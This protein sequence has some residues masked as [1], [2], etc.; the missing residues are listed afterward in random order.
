[1]AIRQPTWERV[2]HFDFSGEMGETRLIVE[3]M[4]KRSNLALTVEG[5]IMDC[6]K[7]VGPDQNRYRVLL[8]GKPYV[9]PPP[10][11]KAHPEQVTVSMMDGFLKR[12][13][14]QPTWQAL[15]A[16]I[17][18]I[19]PLFAR[20][21]VYFASGDPEA[22]AFDVA[23]GMIH[24]AFAQRV[25]EVSAGQWQPCVVPSPQGDGYVAFAAYS[26]THLDGWQPVD[27]ISRAM[28]L[29]FGA[30]VGM[31]AYRAGKEPVR[32]QIAEAQKRV[33]RKLAA[34]ERQLVGEEK[35]ETLRKQGE[36]ILA[37][38]AT[39]TPG[40]TALTAQYDPDGPV[41][42]IDL[43]PR[44]SYADNAKEYFEKYDKAKRA[45][46]D[47]PKLLAR[48]RHE[49]AY[50]QQLA[51]DLD[52]AENWT[53]IDT[54]REE[55]QVAGLWR[56]PHTHGPKGSKLGIRR[57]TT[58]DGFVILIGRNAAQNHE[59]VTEKA[60]GSDLWLHARRIP[61]SHVIVKQGG[62]D[63]SDDV[64][65]RA[66]EIAA[67]YSAARGDTSVEVDVTERRYVRPIKGGRPG[68]VTYKNERT[69]RVKPKK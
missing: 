53:E 25:G 47:V 5:E 52:L 14:S 56:G 29:Y 54:V 60:S 7:R 43:D 31:D 13:T 10:Q 35:I 65:Q 57:L 22:P 8:P 39:L 51:T 9:P 1:M 30:P 62:R 18:G 15:V 36:L 23:A 48:T 69:L 21:I 28:A 34:L 68:M 66:A 58:G 11:D 3:T 41:Y 44:L 37:Y 6:L 64:I 24:A 32:E 42:T 16:N 49:A 12:D 45:A 19:S 33:R 20:E 4:D 2:L 46:A 50:V 40:Q 61:G 26:L 55:L 27:S 38:G 17:A 63:A 67:Y 59:L